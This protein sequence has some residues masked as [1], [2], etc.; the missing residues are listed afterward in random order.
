MKTLSTTL[1]AVTFGLLAASPAFAS[2]GDGHGMKQQSVHARLDRQH[3][4]IKAGLRDHQLTRKEA[5]TLK[6]HQRDIRYLL[7]LFS[8]DG[9]L[10][11]REWRI[12]E[13]ELN[14]SSRQIKRLK[15]NEL[16]RYVDLHQRNNRS[17]Y[18]HHL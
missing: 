3:R 10:S 11:K 16:E 12:L 13:R 9:R 17:R 2:H 18:D 6:S 15:H 4:R 14:H 1:I 8:D 5:K 7:R